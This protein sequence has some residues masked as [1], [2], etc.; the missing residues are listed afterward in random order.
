NL[1]GSGV[2]FLAE[3]LSGPGGMALDVAVGKIYVVESFAGKVTRRNL[4]N[5][6]LDKVLV[7]E[8]TANPEP[9]QTCRDDHGTTDSSDDT[10][11]PCQFF[12]QGIAIDFASPFARATA[13]KVSGD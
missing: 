10:F 12:P 6:T 2:Q 8:A 3:G 7:T 1:D 13:D 9:R 5:G 11:Y 4:T